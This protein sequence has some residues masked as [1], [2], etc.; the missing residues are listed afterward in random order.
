MPSRTQQGRKK[1]PSPPSSSE[2]DS[3]DITTPDCSDDRDS[4]LGLEMDIDLNSEEESDDDQE[5]EEEHCPGGYA[6]VDLEE[7]LQGRTKNVS[8]RIVTKLGWGHFSTVWSV[9]K[10]TKRG[11]T[12][13][14]SNEPLALKVVK[15][16][17]LYTDMADSEIEVFKKIEKIAPKGHPNVLKLRDHFTHRGENGVHR[18]L[19]FDTQGPNLYSI[20]M[21]QGQSD[22]DVNATCKVGLPIN[23]VKRL[24]KQLLE[25]LEFLHVRCNMIHTDLKPENLLLSYDSIPSRPESWKLVLADLGNVESPKNTVE[26]DTTVQTRQYRAPEVILKHGFSYPIDIWS[27]ACLIFELATGEM[28]FCPSKDEDNDP[29]EWKKSDDHLAQI[30][31]LI[32]PL[33]ASMLK[34]NR[35]TQERFFDKNS[36]LRCGRFREIISL[37]QKLCV[38]YGWQERDAE[39][40]SK[41]LMPQLTWMPKA[42][43]RVSNLLLHSWL[44]IT[45]KK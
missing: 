20:L 6:N 37:K 42:R 4:E 1:R 3:S 7:V 13:L 35:V 40:F 39:S 30:L 18:C 10:I 21:D 43:I 34:L 15:S 27:T 23:V 17:E 31:T 9:E 25:A 41:F 19:V 32:G 24:S 16:D 38:I 12:A 22:D 5:P 29:P 36:H 2:E 33:S 11:V 44:T 28:L 8:Y 26:S 45:V 14:V